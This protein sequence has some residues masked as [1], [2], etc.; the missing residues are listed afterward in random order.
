MSPEYAAHGQYSIKS[1]MFSF[2]V[3]VLEIVS[4]KKNIGFCHSDHHLNH[5][6]HVSINS[7]K[8]Y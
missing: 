7:G 3:L 8:S 2:G 4:G 6:G 1:D 5:T